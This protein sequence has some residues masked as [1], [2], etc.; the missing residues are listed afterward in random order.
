MLIPSQ[1]STR[2]IIKFK[3]ILQID[4]S[5]KIF[6]I[7]IIITKSM[8]ITS[9]VKYTNPYYKHN[10]SKFVPNIE[11]ESGTIAR[12]STSVSPSPSPKYA[13][14]LEEKCIPL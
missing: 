13:L 3:I 11:G 12:G 6:S 10:H 5:K 9:K 14:N 8:K 7:T 1:N 2:Q 4:K